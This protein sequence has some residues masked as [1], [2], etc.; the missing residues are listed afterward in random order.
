MVGWKTLCASVLALITS[1]AKQ[2]SPQIEKPVDIHVEKQ[3][4]PLVEKELSSKKCPEC[5][6]IHD[7]S[8]GHYAYGGKQY[9]NSEPYAFRMSEE[10]RQVQTDFLFWDYKYEVSK[11]DTL[12]GIAE[13]IYGD[14][15]KWEDIFQD[16]NMYYKLKTEEYSRPNK[17]PLELAEKHGLDLELLKK[18]RVELIPRKE[19]S[20]DWYKQWEKELQWYIKRYPLQ[21]ETADSKDPEA[22]K[23]GQLLIVYLS[24]RQRHMLKRR[25][26]DIELYK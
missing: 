15:T 5:G 21:G 9:P 22:L 14:K 18:F 17:I 4:S 3:D 7:P 11:G 1:C 2:D 20:E 10:Y 26:P 23:P 16:S 6:W 8:E 13:K 24:M 19:G 25:R 12:E